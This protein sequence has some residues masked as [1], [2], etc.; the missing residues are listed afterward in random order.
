M[1]KRQAGI[2]ISKDDYDP[3]AQGEAEPTGTWQKADESVLA[4]R[5]IRKAKRPAA[6]GGSKA[7]ES[8]RT[9]LYASLE[10]QA[11][12]RCVLVLGVAITVGEAGKSTPCLSPCS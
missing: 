9:K 2:Q 6:A 11:L 4:A 7:A 1:S 12:R 3:D 10:A 5:K 8:P